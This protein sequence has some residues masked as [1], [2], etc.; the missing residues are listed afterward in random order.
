MNRLGRGL[1]LPRNSRLSLKVDRHAALTDAAAPSGLDSHVSGA[2]ISVQELQNRSLSILEAWLTKPMRRLAVLHAR[3]KHVSEG[4]H[5]DGPKAIALLLTFPVFELHNLL[6]KLAYAVVSRRQRL[7]GCEDM[8]LQLELNV[9]DRCL[10]SG[11]VQ[12]LREAKRRLEAAKARLD[13]SYHFDRPPPS[14]Y[15]ESR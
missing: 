1:R 6:F 9:I 2:L 12:G 10:R 13:L 3:L 4:V 14:A 7:A 8:V 11:S 5:V 15:G